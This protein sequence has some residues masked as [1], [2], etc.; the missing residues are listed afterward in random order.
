MSGTVTT[1]RVPGRARTTSGTGG[2]RRLGTVSSCATQKKNACPDGGRLGSLM[3]IPIYQRILQFEAFYQQNC[4]SYP[5]GALGQALIVGADFFYLVLA[6]CIFVAFKHPSE[7][8]T[9]LGTGL[10]L[11]GLANTL[12]AWAGSNLKSEEPSCSGRV[13][14][15]PDE[16]SATLWF[17]WT[18]WVSEV[19]ARRS[20]GWKRA[21]DGLFVTFAAVWGS[22]SVVRL[23]LYTQTETYLG[24]LVGV[25]IC[26]AIHTAGEIPAV[27][28]IA[29][30]FSVWQ[31]VPQK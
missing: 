5:G 21:L 3:F 24:A 11:T 6:I 23:G 22:F 20:L 27:R 8:H 19:L 15:Q 30:R 29:K 10:M 12:F 16:T 18:W 26:L 14:G 9:V 1:C 2:G 4:I 17:V 7:A 25:V 28:A 31:F 13:L